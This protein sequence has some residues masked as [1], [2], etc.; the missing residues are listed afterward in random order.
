MGNVIQ[1]AR[2]DAV[3]RSL[4]WWIA[5][6][7][8]AQLAMGKFFEV[9]PGEE[10]SLFGWHS[11]LGLLVLILM[12]ARVGWRL[13]H[14]APPPP[15]S[16][17]RWQQKVAASMHG[18]LYV[19]LIVLPLSGWLLASVEGDAISFLGWFDLPALPVPGG[20][21]SEDFI[22]ETHEVLGNVLLVL[23]GLH[24]LGG[25]KHHF[26]DRDDVLRRMLPG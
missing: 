16:M 17:P 14:A 13:S 18:L 25:L 12:V 7:A 9:E 3:S 8:F 10:G 21:Q 23:A 11:A 6:M 5:T 20:E 26:V 19:L 24:V 15:A 2:Y 1:T 22:E 4:H